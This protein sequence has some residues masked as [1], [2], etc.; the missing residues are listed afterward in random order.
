MITALQL[1]VVAH[2]E[3]SVIGIFKDRRQFKTDKPVFFRDK[4]LPQKLRDW[5]YNEKRKINY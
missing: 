4:Y 3:G 5:P 2:R 1:N